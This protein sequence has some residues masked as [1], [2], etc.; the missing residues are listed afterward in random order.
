[1]WLKVV[2]PL[3]AA[4]YVA[5]RVTLAL[6]IARAKRRGDTAR[7]DHLRT[8]GFGF[9]RF[10][11]GTTVDRRSACCAV[12]HPRDPLS[13]LGRVGASL[14]VSG[15]ISDP[16]GGGAEF[17]WW[18]EFGSSVRGVEAYFPGCVVDDAVVVAAQAGRGCRGWCCPPSAQCMRWWAWHIT[19]GRRQ[20]GKVQCR[21]RRTRAVQMV[22]VTGRRR[23]PTSRTSLW[24]PRTAGMISASQA[25]RRR[26]SGGRSVPSAVVPTPA[27]SRSPVRVWWSRVT[28]SRAGVPWVSGGRWVSRACWAVATRASQN[29]APWSRRSRCRRRSSLSLADRSSGRGQV[30]GSSA[31]IS[32]APSSADPRPR[33]RTPPARSAADGAGSGSGGRRVPRVPAAASSRRSTASGSTTSTRCRP[34]W[35]SSVASQVAGLADQHLLP[36]AADQVTGRQVRDGR[37]MRSAWSGETVPATS[38]SRVRVSGPVSACARTTRLLALAAVRA[39]RCG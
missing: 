18:F 11:V 37:T 10:V 7:V 30:S 3:L 24:P 36:A 27:A 21:S 28:R 19:G 31:A 29:R 38:A 2:V 9:Y 20:V 26:V 16:F 17:G 8:H 14:F 34:A 4:A 33:T 1:M 25:S 15:S 6:E 12:P 5:Y 32:R 13:D 23:R 39:R 35:A 22:A